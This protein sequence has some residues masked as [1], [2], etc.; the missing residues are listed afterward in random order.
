MLSIA[1]I[2]LTAKEVWTGRQSWVNG[3]I[4]VLSGLATMRGGE[5][6]VAWGIGWETGRMIT[7][8]DWY[9]EM[10]FNY[11]QGEMENL[12]GPPNQTNQEQWYDFYNNY[13]NDLIQKGIIKK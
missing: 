6:G 13:R 9:Q 10:K 11:W 7:N 8:T 3:S 1:G 4:D 12:I 2:A 5:V